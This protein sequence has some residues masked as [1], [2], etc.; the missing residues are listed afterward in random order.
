VRH[1]PNALVAVGDQLNQPFG[2]PIEIVGRIFQVE[3]LGQ[4]RMGLGAGEIAPQRGVPLAVGGNHVQSRAL[5]PKA[6]KDSS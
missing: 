4:D 5:R 2:L 1:D 6:T 3:S